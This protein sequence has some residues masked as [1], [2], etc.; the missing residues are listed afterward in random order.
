[1]NTLYY[2]LGN[3]DLT[4]N[5]KYQRLT[6]HREITE[7]LSLCDFEIEGKKFIPQKSIN[8]NLTIGNDEYEVNIEEITFPIFIP[9]LE[10]IFRQ[11]GKPDKIFLFATNQPHSQDT[12]FLAKIMKKFIEKSYK[13]T[14][15]EIVEIRFAPSDYEEMFKFFRQFVIQH[16]KEIKNNL[17]NYIQLSAGTP[18]MCLSLSISFMEYPVKYYY[19]S[20]EKKKVKEINTFEILNKEK[21]ALI[22]KNLLSAYDYKVILTVLENSP[23]RSFDNIAHILQ[24]LVYLRNFNFEGALE[25]FRKLS[26]E[27]QRE[28]RE[29]GK[30]CSNCVFQEEERIIL[31]YALFEIYLKNEEYIEAVTILFG[32]LDNLRR[33]KVEKLYGIKI[34]KVKGEFKEFNDLCEKYKERFEKKRLEYKNHPSG[35]VLNELLSLCLKEVDKDDVEKQNLR[36]LLEFVQ[37]VEK[38]EILSLRDLGP[39]A[40]GSK[41]ISDSDEEKIKKRGDKLK[42]ILKF[43][44]NIFDRINELILKKLKI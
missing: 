33:R 32:I 43:K 24:I 29:L 35:I 14:D 3:S 37:L 30:I 39:F 18:A 40:H 9:L 2:T 23:F 41:G 26:R 5:H 31:M 12:I 34:K 38:E 13:I 27:Y 15:V 16:Q 22:L 28:F 1:M 11:D 44:E 6:N 19:I 36:T 20:R 8:V 25:E 42:E 7:K 17:N 21:Y 4:I 10:E